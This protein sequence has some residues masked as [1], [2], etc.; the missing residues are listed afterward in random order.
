MFGAATSETQTG[1]DAI[2]DPSSVSDDELTARAVELEARR[3]AVDTEQA[4]VLGELEARRTCDR[5]HGLTTAAW[6]ARETH[7]PAAVSRTRVNVASKLR[8]RLPL[9]ADAL[10]A[11]TISW[12]HAR[13]ITALANPRIIDTVADNQ[14]LLVDLAQRCRF[15]KWHNDI[16]S[17]AR[18]WDQDGGYDPN[19]DP[20]TNRL[21]YGTTLDGL[22]TLAATLTGENAEVVTHAIETR[23][24]ELHR[25]AAHDANASNG[26]LPIPSRSTLR[27][28]A[29]TELIRHA[30][31]IDLDSTK[32]PV[33][34]ATM[35][36]DADEPSVATNPDGVRLA[37]HTTRTLACDAAIT[38]LIVDNLGVPLDLAR[39]ARWATEGQRKAVR[40]R[41]GGCTFPGCDAKVTWCD[42]H[43]CTHWEHGGVSDLANLTSLCR[44]HH[45]VT[46]RTGWSA[47]LDADGW[48][49]FTTASGQQLWGQRHQRQREGPPPRPAVHAPP[50]HS[51]ARP[52]RLFVAPG[53][54]HRPEDPL[55]AAH[56][57]QAVLRRLTEATTHAA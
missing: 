45:G 51:A 40:Q 7:L 39:H 23:T 29:L 47:H 6:L 37:D 5:H 21:S 35:V 57:R 13:A 41:D 15:E 48:T 32:G 9:I 56:A 44:H 12:D 8:R 22:T 53:R 14:H 54:Y 10:A 4:V 50:T 43:H 2:I 28:L 42:I 25:R 27:A 34:E 55:A 46:H 36:I 26:E 38:A 18:L 1:G 52:G 24:D 31:G 11:G 16:R 3:R 33:V 20:A 17:L 30:L 49:V 19:D